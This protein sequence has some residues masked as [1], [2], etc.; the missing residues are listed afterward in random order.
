MRR[1]AAAALVVCGVVGSACAYSGPAEQEN[2]D[3]SNVITLSPTDFSEASIG[4]LPTPML[5][6]FYA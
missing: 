6:D 5:V 3:G 4:S 1:C 2:Y